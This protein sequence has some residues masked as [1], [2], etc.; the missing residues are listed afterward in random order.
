MKHQT[1]ISQ[2]TA[3]EK[4]ALLSGKDIWN[5]CDI[6]RLGVPSI[7]LSD[8][9]SGLRKQAGAGDHLGLNASLPATCWPSAATVANSWNTQL[10]ETLGEAIGEEAQAQNVNVVLGPGLNTKRSPLCGRNF[11]YFSEDPY[12]SGKMAAG[13]IRGI[14]R[15]GVAACPKHFAANSQELRRMANDSVVDLRTLWEL[16]LTN[17]EIAVTEGKPN[18]I[19]SSYNLI[20]GTYAHENKWLLTDVLREEWGFDG[21]VVSDWGGCNDIVA[22]ILA[23]ANLEMPGNGGDSAQQIM[24]ALENGVLS[25]AQLDEC[26]DTL[27]ELIHRVTPEEGA[28]FNRDEHHQFAQTVAEESIV[29]LKNEANI[30]PLQAE[31]HVA[32]IGDFANTPRYQG[33]GSSMVN[34]THLMRALD[35]LAETFPQNMGYAQGFLREDKVNTALLEQ[36]KK[37]AST[38]AVV[39]LYLGLPEVFEVE[40]QDRAH[41]RL[42][43]NQITLLEALAQ[44][45][46]NIVVVLSAGSAVEMPWL[47]NCK[48]LVYSCLGGQAGASATMRV[49]AGQVNPSGKLAETFPLHYEDTPVS[50]YYPGT[51]RTSEY[52]EALFVGYRYFESALKPVRFPFGYGLSYTTFAYSDLDISTS[53]V[54][55][56][57]TNTGKVA[58][59]EVAQLY[60]GLPQSVIFRAATELKGFAKVSLQPGESKRVAIPLDDRTFRY[61]NTKTNHFEV[62]GGRYLISVSKSVQEVALQGQ[63]D[64]AGTNAPDPYQ[65]TPLGC[66][67]IANAGGV[68]GDSFAALL[69][70]E[71]PKMQWDETAPLGMNDTIGQMYYAKSGL[72]R[73]VHRILMHK[74]DTSLKKGK[75]DLNILFIYNMP[76]RGIAK[77]MN[78]MVSMRMAQSILVMVNGHFFKGLGGV[79]RG[80]FA[81]R[82]TK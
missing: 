47:S 30:L 55:F 10:A 64:V 2:M 16:Y 75:P 37:L 1:L 62:E 65:D 7:S 3:A 69:G 73:L 79:I 40:G 71:L 46:P 6:E 54:S 39:L 23:G 5:T 15:R 27:L 36:A 81:K 57:L 63:L 60:V 80:F 24:R 28:T 14:Q 42:P 19:M 44:V 38:A 77:M 12:L 31:A 34:P 49:L 9:P 4:C 29:L 35:V 56:T 53:Q 59:A 43:Q 70:K 52:R 50:Q 51:Q 82:N 66:Y 33:A 48:G 58:G 25:E 26:V 8:G 32:V 21:T 68:S 78:G 18:T 74:K 22:S 67:R 20:N 45:N 41:M 72:A 17:F 13:Y 61:F 11:E 76:F